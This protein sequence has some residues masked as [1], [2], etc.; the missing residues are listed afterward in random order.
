MV[1]EVR[2]VLKL[3]HP[4]VATQGN[5]TAIGLL[6]CHPHFPIS[7]VSIMTNVKPLLKFDCTKPNIHATRCLAALEP[8]NKDG[9]PLSNDN[10]PWSRQVSSLIPNHL[11]S[12][13]LLLLIV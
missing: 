2:G 7:T 3:A 13:G 12:S 5:F 10:S 1:C 9:T 4:E 11:R 6:K 8:Y